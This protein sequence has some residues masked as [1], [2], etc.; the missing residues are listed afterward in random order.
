MTTI[1]PTQEPLVTINE[2]SQYLRVTPRTIYT[3]TK[4]I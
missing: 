3:I 2:L 1:S 4:T